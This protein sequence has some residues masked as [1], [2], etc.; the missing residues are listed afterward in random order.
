MKERENKSVEVGKETW[1]ESDCLIWSLVF[2][3][4]L[5]IEA[6]IILGLGFSFKE[7]NFLLSVLRVY[8]MMHSDTYL[9][10]ARCIPASHLTA[11]NLY[12]CG[13][14]DLRWRVYSWPLA[15]LTLVF[16]VLA[17]SLVPFW[18]Q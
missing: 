1:G 17:G 12:T 18:F 14:D 4:G 16:L 10:L 9:C 15:C 6:S 2:V 13:K 5:Q 11:G 3:F 8:A 7:M